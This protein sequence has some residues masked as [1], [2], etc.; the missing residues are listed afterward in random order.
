[1]EANTAATRGWMA[2]HAA[3]EAPTSQY[4]ANMHDLMRKGDSKQ[5]HDQNM[6]QPNRPL[7]LRPL[8]ACEGESKA[9]SALP[10]APRKTG[11]AHRC[12]SQLPAPSIKLRRAS[13]ADSSAANST[14]DMKAGIGTGGVSPILSTV[15]I[16]G[17]WGNHSRG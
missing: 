10:W 6:N 3:R 9:N 5:N 1:M 4:L 2:K 11:H 8:P 12:S 15:R 17:K 14:P 16:P 7:G 13:L